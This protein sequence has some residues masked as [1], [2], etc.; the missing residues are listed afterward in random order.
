MFRVTQRQFE[1]TAVSSNTTVNQVAVMTT[2]Y[3]NHREATNL[4]SQF[5]T[6]L[7]AACSLTPPPLS[8]PPISA[9]MKRTGYTTQLC[10]SSAKAGLQ[11]CN[12]NTNN[13]TATEQLR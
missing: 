10:H 11:K 3:A 13:T 4:C 12:I 8:T 7:I 2:Y 1:T 9:T 6:G 5:N